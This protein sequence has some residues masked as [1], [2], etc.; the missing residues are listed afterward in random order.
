MNEGQLVFDLGKVENFYPN[1]F[2]EWFHNFEKNT[3]RLV[4]KLE[5]L[6]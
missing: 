1:D 5:L 6:E 4:L 2:Y 3:V